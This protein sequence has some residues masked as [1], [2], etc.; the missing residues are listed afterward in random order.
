MGTIKHKKFYRAKETIN[1]MKRQHTEWEKRFVN[2]MTD[3]QLISKM[4]SSQNSMSK[5]KKQKT[6]LKNVEG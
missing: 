6:L 3:K 2:V 1:K 5:N 4:K